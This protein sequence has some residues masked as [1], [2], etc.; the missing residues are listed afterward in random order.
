LCVD[1]E[2]LLD[3]LLANIDNRMAGVT[4][5]LALVVAES[6]SEGN[7]TYPGNER[8]GYRWN[9]TLALIREGSDRCR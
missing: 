6:S 8:F 7:G 9:Q 4:D 1:V 2:K 3:V 5:E